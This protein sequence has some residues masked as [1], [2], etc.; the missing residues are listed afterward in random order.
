MRRL[1]C[2]CGIIIYAVAQVVVAEEPFDYFANS[3]SVIGLK[4]YT[5]GT[6]VTPKNELM[7]AGG[8]LVRIQYGRELTRLSRGQVKTNLDGWLPIILLHAA[9]GPARYEFTL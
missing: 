9:D 7:L 5:F 8:K 1:A 6:R 4:D 3:W 2:I